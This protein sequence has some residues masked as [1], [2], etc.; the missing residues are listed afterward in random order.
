LE[1]KS[2]YRRLSLQ[3]RRIID[4]VD[5]IDWLYSPRRPSTP[6]GGA[7]RLSDGTATVNL[8]S[9]NGPTDQSVIQAYVQE[10]DLRTGQVLFSWSRRSRAL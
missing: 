6:T 1:G 9:I 8:S 3:A 4:K 10:I 7:G 2:T 5:R